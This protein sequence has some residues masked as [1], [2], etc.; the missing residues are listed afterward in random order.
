MLPRM[1]ELDLGPER[2]PF[3]ISC[4]GNLGGVWAMN[5]VADD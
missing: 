4:R 5:G 3:W 2:E 1:T